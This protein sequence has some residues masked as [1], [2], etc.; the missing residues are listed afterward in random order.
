M[1][2]VAYGVY[3]TL[4]DSEKW[5]PGQTES[6]SVLLAI[7][8]LTMIFSEIQ[9][10]IDFKMESDLRYVWTLLLQIRD[11]CNDF[12]LSRYDGILKTTSREK[13]T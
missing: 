9:S 6:D 4:P 8:F 11:E 12:Y 10:K 2:G 13:R 5:H 1:K 3:S 7:E